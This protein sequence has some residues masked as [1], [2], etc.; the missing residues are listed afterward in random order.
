[1][2][3]TGG[4]AARLAAAATALG[5]VLGGAAGTA[6][7]ETKRV[8]VIVGG[9]VGNGD[10]PAL[11]FAETDAG[12]LAAVLGELGGFAPADVFLLQGR[13]LDDLRAT[14]DTVA[15]RVA[16]WRRRP[17]ARVVLLFYFSGHSDGQ[18]LEL[19]RERYE[20]GE[21]RRWL[22]GAGADVRLAIIDTCKSGALLAIKGGTRAPPF[23]IR[24]A[25]DPDSAGEVLLTSSAADENALESREIRGSFFSHHLVSGLRGAADS[26]GDGQVTLSE[27]YRYAFAR[28]VSA[29]AATL[30]G[31]QHPAFDFRLSGQG[32]LV[33][34]QIARPSAIIEVRGEFERALVT[35]ARKDQV[36]AELTSGSAGRIAV[37]PGDYTVYGWRRGRAYVARLEVGAGESRVLDE[38]A[39]AA[40]S[41]FEARA[42]GGEPE[43][44]VA[45]APAPPAPVPSEHQLLVGGGVTSGVAAG[46][47]V[48]ETLRLSLRGPGRQ[49]WSLALDVASGRGP[50]FRETRA[51]IAGGLGL[52][53]E[54][55]S[56][57]AYAGVDGGAGLVI[58]SPDERPQLWSATLAAGFVAG[59]SVRV[60]PGL[61]L[62][63]EAKAPLTLVRRDSRLAAVFLPAA[64]AGV[65]VDL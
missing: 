35:L 18:A 47:G 22:A 52:A 10:R 4:R 3:R 11:R 1:M 6:A 49:P 42:K 60:S 7:G 19:G 46:A 38:R 62:G 41:S 61:S 44:V 51:S 16:D 57:R 59:A 26:S 28:T 64:W 36:I 5:C 27:A 24:L 55:G 56:G 20:F 54:S 53:R 45:A 21:L 17:G 39:F 31:T 14:L 12:K 9:N 30:A 65:V 58:Q 25:S 50:G 48:L 33:L 15:G 34:T 40:A 2:K 29:T 37:G 32:E 43:A 13:T 63:L 8:A 23:E